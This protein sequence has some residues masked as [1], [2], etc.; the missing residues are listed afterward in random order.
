MVKL[1][2]GIAEGIDF[3]PHSIQHSSEIHPASYPMGTG[4]FPQ[5]SGYDVKINEKE[6][7]IFNTGTRRCL[8]FA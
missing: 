6:T 8:R 5:E 1:D 2:S 3:A 7:N 4:F